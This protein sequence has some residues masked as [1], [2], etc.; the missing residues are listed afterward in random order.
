M[1]SWILAVSRLLNPWRHFCP[2]QF[3]SML[4]KSWLNL[5]PNLFMLLGPTIITQLNLY[6]VQTN[7]TS[8]VWKEWSFPWISRRMLWKYSIKTSCLEYFCLKIGVGKINRFNT[9]AIYNSKLKFVFNSIYNNSQKVVSL[10]PT[11]HVQNV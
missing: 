10:Y 3:M 11:K 6:T 4:T 8:V 5:F 9:L 1:G 7:E 2:H